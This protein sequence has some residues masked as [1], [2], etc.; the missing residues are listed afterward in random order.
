MGFF[1]GTSEFTVLLSVS[2][3]MLLCMRARTHARDSV[4]C[5]ACVCVCVCASVRVWEM[6][7]RMAALSGCAL[8]PHTYGF[9]DDVAIFASIWHV[10]SRTHARTHA[11]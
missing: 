2:V 4:S 11:P 7:A 1:L 3:A 9:L 8:L 10:H 5:V 6:H